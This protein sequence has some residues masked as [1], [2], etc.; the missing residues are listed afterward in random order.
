MLNSLRS[1]LFVINLGLIIVGFGGFA[2]WAGRQM[3]QATWDDYGN[4][5]YI[6][7]LNQ[8][9][10]LVEPMEENPAQA[11]AILQNA[12]TRLSADF[13]LFDARGNFIYSTSQP[14]ILADIGVYTVQDELV[15]SAAEILYENQR[16]GYVQ[17]VTSATTPQSAIRQRWLELLG[18][19]LGFSLVSIIITL[20]LLNTLTQP[21]ARLRKSALQIAEGD[22][23]HRLTNLPQNEIGAVGK[24]FNT[25]A[26]RV[27]ALVAEQRAFA[28][29][30]SH[31]LRTPLT[32]IRLRN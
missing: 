1:R 2:L 27:S 18:A 8:A 16:I 29:N 5:Q 6:Y 17:M 7:T 30:A 26:Q 15:K 4:S 22:L 23:A 3:A 20:W 32:T 31:E 10:Q 28:S 11:Q 14:M 24:A 21:L 12:A 19:F 13:A 25:M 9:N